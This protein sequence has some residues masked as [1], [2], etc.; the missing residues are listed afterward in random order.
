MKKV[1]IL[2]LVAI[3]CIGFAGTAKADSITV[4]GVQ[5]TGTVTGTT[6]TLTVQ[7]LQASCVNWAIGDI[8][9]KG[10]SYTGT[11]GNITEPL[12]Y[13][14]Q[15]GGQNNGGATACNST[16]LQT[17]VCWNR[18]GFFTLGS[19]VNTFEASIA[20]GTVSDPLHVQTVVFTDSTG[21]TR[22]TGI[23]DDLTL[24]PPSVP[25]PASLVLL[26]LSLAGV[27]FLRR[28]RS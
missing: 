6:A 18:S 8:T 19:G 7:C 14:V 5:F 23:S 17:A 11:A 15:N 13:V 16:Q 26:G 2:A 10:F 12:G 9:L 4:Q 1:L 25:E 27:P 22:V 28:R 24:T 21:A 3:V 20:N